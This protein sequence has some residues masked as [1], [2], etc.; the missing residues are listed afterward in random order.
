MEQRLSWR[1]KNGRLTDQILQLSWSLEV[2]N[3]SHLQEHEMD[4]IPAPIF[5]HKNR[6]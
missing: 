5:H 6:Y 1:R 3:L 2:R 4:P